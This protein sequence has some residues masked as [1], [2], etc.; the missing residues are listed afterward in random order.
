MPI[1]IFMGNNLE[2]NLNVFFI[3]C[4]NFITKPQDPYPRA[5]NANHA[6]GLR[7]QS[8]DNT[9][10]PLVQPQNVSS[11]SYHDSLAIQVKA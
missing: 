10:N 5:S 6:S 11:F 9:L 2:S 4:L 3:S 1:F 7:F 8:F